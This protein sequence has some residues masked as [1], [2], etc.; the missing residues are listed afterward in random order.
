LSATRFAVHGGV[1]RREFTAFG[2]VP[3]GVLDFSVNVNPYGPCDEIRE[4]VR[5]AVIDRYADPSAIV[6]RESLGAWLGTEAESVVL[7]NGAVEVLWAAARAFL[8]PGDHALV[9]EPAF[10]EFRRAAELVHAVV[11]EC[12]ARP[13]DDFAFDDGEFEQALRT[14]RPQVAHLATPANPTGRTV[15]FATLRSLAAAHPTTLF[16]VDVSFLTLGERAADSSG[17]GAKGAPNIVWVMSLTKELSVPGVRIGLALA[18]SPLARQLEA[19]IPPWSVG[20]AAQAVAEAAARP[21]VRR[22]VE[23]SRRA[24]SRDR[25]GLAARLGDLGLRVHASDAPYV[26]FH[27]DPPLDV[28]SLRRGLLV[29]HGVLVRD[30]ASFGLPE[31]V[32]VAARSPPDVDRLTLALKVELR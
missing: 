14:H 30:A 10:S 19:Q 31:H 4:A 18:P 7:G 21:S 12:R 1:H 17:V 23:D 16:V 5:R 32:R 6:A 3:E 9:A 22:F 28:P 20:A 26:L 8:R 29:R 11:V 2:V 24:L 25:Q 27:R 13:D 15:P